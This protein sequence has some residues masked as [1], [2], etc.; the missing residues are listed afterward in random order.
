MEATIVFLPIAALTGFALG[1]LV[2]L[3]AL[4]LPSGQPLLARPACPVCQAPLPRWSW[5]I[6]RRC[7]FCRNFPRHQLLS[8]TAIA[9][10]LAAAWWRFLADPL[11]A[12]R[13]SLAILFLAVIARIDWAHHLIYLVTIIPA[14]L[15]GLLLTLLA[16][17]AAFLAALV[18]SLAGA[19]LFALFYG[20][21]WLLYR[22]PALGSG[23][24]LLAASIGALTGWQHLLHALALGMTAAA[25]AAVWLLA[26][27][28]ASRYS[29][30]PYGS[31]L[32]GGTI[33]A[34]LLWGPA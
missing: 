10:L 5:L 21:G 29:Y 32:A 31:Y 26:R 27:R 19:L 18:G 23:D 16:S 33:L 12:F 4:R 3:T 2:E 11:Q 15:L 6:P 8:Q 20:L 24:V 9:V 1:A 30:L 28:R 14:L 25:L 22:R 7:A 13:V 17:P 34:L